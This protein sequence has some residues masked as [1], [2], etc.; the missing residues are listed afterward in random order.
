[1]ARPSIKN[2]IMDLLNEMG[3]QIDEQAVEEAI[4]AVHNAKKGKKTVD[5]DEYF[6]GNTEEYRVAYN[7]EA[8]FAVLQSLYYSNPELFKQVFRLVRVR[9][10]KEA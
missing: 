2:V 3:M 4:R 9:N 6:S 10:K 7:K 8:P 5:F 1:M